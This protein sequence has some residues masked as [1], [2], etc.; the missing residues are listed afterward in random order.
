MKKWTFITL[1]IL[2]ATILGSTVLRE[3]IANA[4]QS[5][6]ANII[7]PL[8][9]QGNVKVHEQGTANVNVTNS[10]VPVHEQGTT[11]VKASDQTQVVLKRDFATDQDVTIAV[12]A[13]REIRVELNCSAGDELAIV[14][15]LSTNAFGP[16]ILDILHCEQSRVYETPGTTLVLHV[17]VGTFDQPTVVVYGRSN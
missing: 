10:T 1:L 9:G 13:Y 5:V 8:D 6:D 17:A 14:D 15:P 12:D 7:G 2:G 11:N 4:A 3:P 16:N